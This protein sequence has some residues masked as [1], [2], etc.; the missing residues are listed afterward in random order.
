MF[1]IENCCLHGAVCTCSNKNRTACLE[2]LW[3]AVIVHG[4]DFNQSACSINTDLCCHLVIYFSQDTHE[5]LMPRGVF[6]Y[7]C[8]FHAVKK[9]PITTSQSLGQM[10]LNHQQRY[11][12]RADVFMCCFMFCLFIMSYSMFETKE[13]E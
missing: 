7:R 9:Q 6:I 5:R 4:S 2:C 12:E 10:P 11:C 3:N 13:A 1:V 8:V